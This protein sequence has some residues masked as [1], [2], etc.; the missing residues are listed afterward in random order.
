MKLETIRARL[1][2]WRSAIQLAF[3]WLASHS[4]VFLERLNFGIATRLVA[5]FVGVG[6]LVLAANVFVVKGVLIEKTTEITRVAPAPMPP[7]VAPAPAKETEPIAIARPPSRRVVTSD[8]LTLA[9]QRHA[10]AVKD[11]ETSQTEE[12][13]SEY[14]TSATQLDEAAT[15]F[16]AQATAISGKSFAKLSAGVKT[17]SADAEELLR[18]ADER[19][20]KVGQ[21]AMLFE[22]IYARANASVKDAWKMF[23]RIVARQS[24]LQL[25][26]DLD[27]LRRDSSALETA[28]SA[29]A[30]APLIETEAAVV[31]NLK[32]NEKSFRRSEGDQWYTAMSQDLENLVA[33]REAIIQLNAQ[34]ASRSPDVA[35][36]AHNL[37]ALIPTKIESPLVL[38]VP[39]AKSRAVPDP[40][41]RTHSSTAA[42]ASAATATATA[43]QPVITP[44]PAIVETH[45][46]TRD[47]PEN[48]RKRV[49]VGWI[50]AAVLMLMSIIAFGTVLS[51]VRPVRRLHDATL[52]LAKGDTS[53]QVQRGGIPEL[54]TLA[55]A[56]N[57]MAN[58]LAAA[59]AV[60][61]NYQADLE[62]KVAERT[63]QLQDLAERDPLTGLPNRRELFV[64]LNAA[65]TRART[66]GCLVGV[67]FL[68]IDNFKYINDGMGHAFGDRVL[69][70]LARR[71]QE[72][73]REIGFAS[74]LGGDEFTVV[75]EHAANLEEIRRAGLRVVQAFQTPLSV[76]GRDLIVSVSVG[77][78]VFP[79][80]EQDAEALLM[81]ADAALFRA[82][83]LGRSQLSI[84]TPELVEAAAAKFTTEQGLR[85]AVERGEF[86]LL[87]QP[88]LNVETMEVSLVEALIRWRM[89]DGS[90]V[91]PGQ[92]LAIAE[93]SGLIIEISDWVLRSAIEAAA[94]W[95][96]GEWPEA[97]VA[98]NVSPRQLLDNRF[99]DRVCDLLREYDLPN[100]CIEI[101]LTESVLQTG[102]ATIDALRGLRA[103]GVA[104]ALDDFGTG[105]SSLASVE[106]LPLSRIKLDRTLIARVDTSAR[107][108]AIARAIIGMC[109]GLGLE[110]TAEGVERPEQFALLA[111]YSGMYLQGY[112][113]SAAVS[114]DQVMNAR[115]E[116]SRRAQN[117]LLNAPTIGASS[118]IEVASHTAT[119][120]TEVG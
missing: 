87:F 30:A 110:I 74:R 108:C 20:A 16:I 26:T 72:A 9:L 79:D 75:F 43:L 32:I 24:L 96:H 3:S 84:F 62:A 31:S 92:F 100:R 58:E 106:Q 71:L 112:L 52:R 27:A 22:Q 113:F 38:A 69:I 91:A 102:T 49:L 103:Q 101:E 45:S 1:S 21:Y 8:A 98:I 83:A 2:G 94:Y 40:G 41:V 50:S 61:Q 63:R 42:P 99:G 78:S 70:S 120:L 10:R 86:E 80:H 11:R 95:H 104:I 37:A 47:T 25:S 23:G 34:L 73:T 29:A 76:D 44:P 7:P 64:L 119:K 67:F 88:E 115:I 57:G 82:K 68:D 55:I 6:A 13:Q 66:D 107:S 109:Q 28:E 48:R 54:D 53:V 12:T 59:K 114:R 18:L 81:A 93:E 46:V 90:L 89:P 65:I 19:H 15:S 35:E 17:Y 77:A 14:Q 97:R 85:R 60:T 56:F 51:V 118:V 36:S 117:L 105:Y 111:N 4:H 5:A 39:K 116:V 33:L